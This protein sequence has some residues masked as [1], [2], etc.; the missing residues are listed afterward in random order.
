MDRIAE[1]V[2]KYQSILV[3]YMEGMAQ[4]RNG[5]A[6]DSLE[7]QV[8]ADQYRNHFQLVR[9]GWNKHKFNFLVLLHFDIH[10]QTGKIWIQQNNTEWLVADDLQKYGVPAT[11]IVLGFKPEYIRAMG[12]FAV[13]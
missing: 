8:I 5:T 12:A 6:S 11:D 4:Q 3:Q 10:P 1:K 7:Y 13:N 9:L 2:K